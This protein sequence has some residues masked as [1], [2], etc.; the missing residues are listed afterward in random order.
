LTATDD[1]NRTH[2]HLQSALPNDVQIRAAIAG[3]NRRSLSFLYQASSP[4]RTGR[5]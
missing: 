2:V 1:S 3:M 4:L 5:N